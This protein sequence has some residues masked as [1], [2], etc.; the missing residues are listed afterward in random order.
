MKR[1]FAIGPGGAPVISNAH[2]ADDG[3]FRF[4]F[5]GEPQSKRWIEHSPDTTI[6]TPISPILDFS[7]RQ[8]AVNIN[9][10]SKGFFRLA[11][12]PE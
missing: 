5:D 11:T 3:S 4:D 12:E 6:W 9:S 10:S 2:V 1:A 7:G 8:K